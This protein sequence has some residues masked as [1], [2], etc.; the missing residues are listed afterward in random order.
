M[1]RRKLADGARNTASERLGESTLSHVLD[2]VYGGSPIKMLVHVAEQRKLSTAE[3][4]RIRA[5]C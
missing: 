2:E 1:F 3:L 5:R 4:A